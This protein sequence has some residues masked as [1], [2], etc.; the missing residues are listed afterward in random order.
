MNIKHPRCLFLPA[1]TRQQAE[2]DAPA[3]ACRFLKIT[4][5]FMAFDS[6]AS[7]NLWR[8]GRKGIHKAN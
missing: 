5:G 2:R 1:K 3:W 8:A 6:D 4:G 7:R